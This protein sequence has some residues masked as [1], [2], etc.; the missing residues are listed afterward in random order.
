MPDPTHTRGPTAATRSGLLEALHEVQAEHGYVPRAEA[1]ALSQ[2]IGVPLARIFE[3][4]T[5]YSYFRL[6]KPGRVTISVCQ[7]TSCHL[8]GGPRLLDAI[9]ERL[10]IRAGECTPDGAYQ[11]NVVRCLGC[12]GRSPVL[13]VDDTVYSNVEPSDLPA[14]L[15]AHANGKP[16]TSED[17]DED[18]HG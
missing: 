17:R 12:C 18:G 13:M 9:Q 14:I 6:E 16:D 7:G 10:G 2:R 4:L 5:F 3:V 15:R 1:L 8:Q 11:L